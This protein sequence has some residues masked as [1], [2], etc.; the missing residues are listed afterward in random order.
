MW[1]DSPESE[2]PHALV[3]STILGPAVPST[4]SVD[5]DYVHTLRRDAL[6][7]DSHRPFSRW[8]LH[9]QPETANTDDVR[10]RPRPPTRQSSRRC[11][12]RLPARI[13]SCEPS[14]SSAPEHR[15]VENGGA[16]GLFVRDRGDD[17]RCGYARVTRA[18]GLRKNR[19]RPAEI[20][21]KRL[22]RAISRSAR[23]TADRMLH[24]VP[25]DLLARSP[26]TSGPL[27]PTRLESIV[28]SRA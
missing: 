21:Q 16:V 24:D 25:T 6:V 1:T 8:S 22:G 23:R 18:S 4:A 7:L 19:S 3:I 9:F 10:L 14:R 17:D 11:S 5:K 20:P 28:A 27:R 26:R 2:A 13:I 15:D 12:A